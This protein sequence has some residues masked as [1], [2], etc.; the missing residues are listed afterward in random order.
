MGT[1]AVIL[2]ENSQIVCLGESVSIAVFSKDDSGWNVIKSIP[3]SINFSKDMQC[4]REELLELMEEL[5]DCKIIVGK[6]VLGV[7]YHE[8][9]KMGFAIFEVERF[10]TEILDA[11]L[12]DMKCNPAEE[13]EPQSISPVE[14]DVAGVYF[15]DLISLQAQNP[16][17]SSKMALQPFLS[18]TPFLR[19]TIVCSHLPPWIEKFI[20][21]KGFNLETK[22]TVDG[23]TQVSIMKPTC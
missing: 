16:D 14:T 12:W 6:Q 7:A 21:G 13:E 2:D 8:F 23:K 19:L 10:T 15:L 3:M 22:K 20:A 11:I 4:V 17:I 18:N 9:D 5:D 1:I